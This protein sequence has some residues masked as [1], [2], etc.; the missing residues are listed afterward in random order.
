[1]NEDNLKSSESERIL[2]NTSTVEPETLGWGDLIIALLVI[3]A[4]N[5]LLPFAIDGGLDRPFRMLGEDLIISAF[6]LYVIWAMACRK[7]EKG[8]LEG[9]KIK[10]ID[11]KSI[12]LFSA[13]G[14]GLAVTGALLEFLFPADDTPLDILVN[15]RGGLIYVSLT[16]VLIAPWLEELYYRG[17]I[18]SV[19][20]NRL[21][22]R[23][24]L[25]YIT[26]WFSVIHFPQY[27]G[28]WIGCLFIV[29]LASVLT[30]LRYKYK[31]LTPCIIVHFCNN[32]CAIASMWIF[33]LPD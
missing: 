22:P 16:A 6:M 32:L 27:W 4:F 23:K 1:M 21:G 9:F 14:V 3:W 33:E 31:S 30:W 13:L 7:F 11:R 15:N 24:A 12:L 5:L 18:Y 28:N 29:V 10:R 8:F 20:E 19:F 26:I 25:V 2:S 17:F